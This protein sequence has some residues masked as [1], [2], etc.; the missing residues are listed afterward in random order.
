MVWDYPGYLVQEIAVVRES[1][2]LLTEPLEG[3]LALLAAEDQVESL[4]LV[5]LYRVLMKSNTC[6][7]SSPPTSSPDLGMLSVLSTLLPNPSAS[8]APAPPMK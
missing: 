8:A 4:Y 2:H 3:R 5:R 7:T 6:R 1:S